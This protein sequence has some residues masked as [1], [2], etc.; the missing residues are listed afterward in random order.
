MSSPTAEEVRAAF[1]AGSFLSGWTEVTQA[2]M[3]RFAEVT[4]DPDW[5]HID[6]VRAAREGP[7]EGTIAFGFWTLSLLTWFLRESM[8]REYPMGAQYGFNYGLDRVRF[9][10]PIPVGSRIRNR[11]SLTNVTRKG[12]GRFVVTTH[13]EV[14]VEGQAR[15][16]MVADWLLM[17][18][19]PPDEAA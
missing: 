3:D 1:G 8:G 4:K 9:L 13:N 19:Y 15:P 5:M 6:P 2:L 16:A 12:P 11:M 18:V 17:L 10:A 14:E 7:L